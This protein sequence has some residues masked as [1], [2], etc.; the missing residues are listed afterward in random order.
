MGGGAGNR[1]LLGRSFVVVG[2]V[3]LEGIRVL[4][5]A[6]A[7]GALGAVH[8]RVLRA[9]V[10]LQVVVRDP[11]LAHRAES[12]AEAS[13]RGRSLLR[14]GGGGG[15]RRGGSAEGGEQGR[16]EEEAPP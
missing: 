10:P 8:L 15:W 1:R 4:E 7:V 2:D 11:L 12:V 13:L 16:Q 6:G 14:G 5:D 9:D 3:G